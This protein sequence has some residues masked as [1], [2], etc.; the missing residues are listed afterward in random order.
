MSQ[1]NNKI[2]E[3]MHTAKKNFQADFPSYSEHKPLSNPQSLNFSPRSDEFVDELSLPP[4]SAELKINILSRYRRASYFTNYVTR[5]C[6]WSSCKRSCTSVCLHQLSRSH[7]HL[8]RSPSFHL[9]ILLNLIY[10]LL[11]SNLLSTFLSVRHFRWF[12][13]RPPNKP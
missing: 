8:L 1:Q 11:L 10:Y 6:R 12:S 3:I 2:R 4:F 7:S 9:P 13:C 5:D